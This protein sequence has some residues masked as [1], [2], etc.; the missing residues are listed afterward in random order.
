MVD[1]HDQQLACGERGVEVDQLGA[2]ARELHRQ[3]ARIGLDDVDLLAEAAGECGG[4]FDRGTFAEIVDIGLEGEA[5]AGDARIGMLRHQHFGATDDMR[6]L[7]EIDL[8][9]SEE[10]TSELQSLMRMSYAVFCLKK[11]KPNYT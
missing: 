4:D 2:G 9:R 6:G 1:E 11:T 7:G 3:A 10:H 8:A 5:E